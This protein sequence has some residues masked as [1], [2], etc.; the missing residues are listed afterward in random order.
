MTESSDEYCLLYYV[1]NVLSDKSVSIAAIIFFNSSD[2]VNG[3]CTMICAP[4]WQTE[5]RAL[6]P[7]TDLEMLE[8][9]LTEIRGRLLSPGH[10]FDMIRQLEDSFSNVVQVSQRRKYP[11]ARDSETVGA[12]A[13]RLLVKTSRIS[14]R[15]S[16]ALT[17]TYETSR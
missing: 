11:T 14:P 2:P 13:H 5:V 1:P 10:R 7:D 12:F 6:D 16:G 15:S 3:V 17:A 9:L 8:A 4:D